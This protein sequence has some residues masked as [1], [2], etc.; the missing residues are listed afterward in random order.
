MSLGLSAAQFIRTISL[1]SLSSFYLSL[2]NHSLSQLYM[3]P[4]TI[5][6]KPG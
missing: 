3:K 2:V 4:D 1:D 5:F 6:V